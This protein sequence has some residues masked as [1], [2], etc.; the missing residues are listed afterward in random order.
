MKWD[1]SSVYKIY[2]IET[3]KAFEWVGNKL[4]L[5]LHNE[6]TTPTK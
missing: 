3:E 1:S 6:Q 5:P 4:K 2:L